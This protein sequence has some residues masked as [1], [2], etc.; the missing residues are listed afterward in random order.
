MAL[1]SAMRAHLVNTVTAKAF[2]VKIKDVVTAWTHMESSVGLVNCAMLVV[3][4]H[5]RMLHTLPC[6]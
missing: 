1:G 3:P 2:Q 4:L 5:P 6:Y